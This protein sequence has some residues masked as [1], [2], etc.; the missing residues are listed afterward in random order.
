M[1][2][3]RCAAGGL[4]RLCRRQ[5]NTRPS[6]RATPQTGPM[7][8]PAIATPETLPAAPVVPFVG[9][10]LV[11]I[12]SEVLAIGEMVCDIWEVVMGGI[13]WGVLNTEVVTKS[14]SEESGTIL[15]VYRYLLGATFGGVRYAIQPLPVP[16]KRNRSPSNSAPSLVAA[17]PVTHE[18]PGP[19]EWRC[20]HQKLQ[21][22][23]LMSREK[24]N[25]NLPR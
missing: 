10:L 25:L 24:V 16:Q 2:T 17:I 6:R 8:A 21:D 15:A 12:E 5:R 9:K 19:L 1:L 20:K 13:C 22:F 14:V 4:L 7:T 18:L 23:T 3:G 11:V